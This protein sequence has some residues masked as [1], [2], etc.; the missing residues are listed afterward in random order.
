MEKETNET[1]DN[2]LYK[3]VKELENN[4]KKKKK[5]KL[6][7]SWRYLTRICTV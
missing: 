4:K 3:D 2:D 7:I 6:N 5:K 1:K